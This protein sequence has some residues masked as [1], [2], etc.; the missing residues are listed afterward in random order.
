MDDS[1]ERARLM[2]G[3][4]AGSFD[5]YPLTFTYAG[6]AEAPQG[7]ADVLDARG[8]ANFVM[9]LFVYR[10]THL[11]VMVTWESAPS[12]ETRLY[13]ADYRAVDPV[14]GTPRAT[15]GLLELYDG[16][17]LIPALIGLFAISEAFVMIE[18]E[19]IVRHQDIQAAKAAR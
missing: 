15:F 6:Q 17:P 18:T 13:F 1:E 3:L 9:R 10:D 2:L 16:V 5:G 11:P 19:T 14:F 12:M 4:F 8:P 7:M